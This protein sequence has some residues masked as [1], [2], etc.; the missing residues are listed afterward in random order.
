MPYFIAPDEQKHVPFVLWLSDGF[1][2]SRNLDK[3]Q[4]QKI[5]SRLFSHD[6]LFHSVLGMMGVQTNVYN[7][8]LDI[9]AES[10]RLE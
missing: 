1:E 2:K 8:R 5:S 9:F 6:N 4:L 7:P 3:S 10:K